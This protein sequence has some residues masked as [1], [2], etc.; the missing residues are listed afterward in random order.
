MNLLS[1]QVKNILKKDNSY[2]N[3]IT[4]FC[5]VLSFL[6]YFQDIKESDYIKFHDDHSFEYTPHFYSFIK[7][8]FDAKLV[9]DVDEMT[10]FLKTYNCQSA[11]KLWMKE[12][13]AVLSNN[14]LVEKTNL[15]FLKK[16]V[17]SMIRLERVLPGSW[18]IDVETGTWLVILQQFKR[19]L[20][21]IYKSEKKEMN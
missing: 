10:D 14:E 8:L 6:P 16:A 17:F 5:E 4:H 15:C 11:Y 13:N 2:G 9:E 19:I 21:Q 1:E 18:G 20:P 3:D 12:M 7:A